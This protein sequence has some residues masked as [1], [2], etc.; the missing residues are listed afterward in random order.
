M[1]F[2]VGRGTSQ[3]PAANGNR[4]LPVGGPSSLLLRDSSPHL[5][6]ALPPLKSTQ[7]GLNYNAEKT[8]MC[9]ASSTVIDLNP[10]V[11]PF[12]TSH[13]LL[14]DRA[15]DRP[16]PRLTRMQASKRKKTK[17]HNSNPNFGNEPDASLNGRAT[18]RGSGSTANSPNDSELS[19]P[20][21][22]S[23]M[24]IREA[25]LQLKT[26]QQNLRVVSDEPSTRPAWE[27]GAPSSRNGSSN[28][29]T[30]IQRTIRGGQTEDHPGTIVVSQL[31]FLL[32]LQP[33]IYSMS[34]QNKR[35]W[36]NSRR[37][38]NANAL[39]GDLHPPKG[40]GLAAL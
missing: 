33:L 38:W 21:A 3:L 29:I 25:V 2:P 32:Y 12:S 8:S 11:K 20:G 34:F 18:P 26:E 35:C 15:Q 7:R 27:V 6:T 17:R 22:D 23:H 39:S 31:S 28:S 30:L 13:G 5:C 24:N 36:H 9:F 40:L 14:G 37:S 19:Q 10:D 4:H 1:H 16:R